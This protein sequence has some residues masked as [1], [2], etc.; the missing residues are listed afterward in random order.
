M[1]PTTYALRGVL[2]PAVW[3]GALLLAGWVSARTEGE[4]R[5]WLGALA[6]G[7]GYLLGYALVLGGVP[8]F[9]PAGAE[10]ALFHLGAAAVLV[11]LLEGRSPAARRALRAGLSLAAPWVLLRRMVDQWEQTRVVM[12]L[13]LLG[14]ALLVAWSLLEAW[15]RRRP[16]ASVP[17]VLWLSASGAAWILFLGK[18]AKLG[19]LAG[20]L[21][22][23][24]G[25]AAVVSWLR[26]ALVLA[27]GAGVA[28]WVLGS[29]AITGGYLT[30]LP[31]EAAALLFAAPLSGW[32]GELGPVRRMAPARAVVARLLLVAAPLAAALWIVRR[33]LPAPPD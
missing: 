8:R 23:T 22:G 17:L 24:L 1:D 3:A 9:P 12:E 25:A 15:A 33:S 19:Q 14:A 31:R 32:L 11:G 13:L 2:A 26:P 30:S 16:G 7:G 20:A 4:R 10:A 18:S 28:A 6:V 5:G 21:A 29:L 27:G